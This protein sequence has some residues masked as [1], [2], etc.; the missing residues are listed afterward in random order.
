M[1]THQQVYECIDG[2]FTDYNIESFAV[3]I[4]KQ[5]QSYCR[6]IKRALY[7]KGGI[8][9]LSAMKQNIIKRFNELKPIYD[10]NKNGMAKPKKP[11]FN[12]RGIKKKKQNQKE[13][14]SDFDDSES[15]IE[16]KTKSKS[17]K[18]SKTKKMKQ[19]NYWIKLRLF[20]QLMINKDRRLFWRIRE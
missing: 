6:D 9:P 10:S 17:R 15:E 11:Q 13:E 12:L 16:T 14:R 7:A 20:Q 8:V 4:K 18:Q 3:F 1:G 5:K 19:R 2:L